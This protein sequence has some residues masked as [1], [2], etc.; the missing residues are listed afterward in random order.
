[1]EF[2]AVPFFKGAKERKLFS[3]WIAS[4]AQKAILSCATLS[5]CGSGGGNKEGSNGRCCCCG[6]ETG[7]EECIKHKQIGPP[8]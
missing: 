7:M 2:V 4:G 5:G 1:M 3:L 6:E 8:R